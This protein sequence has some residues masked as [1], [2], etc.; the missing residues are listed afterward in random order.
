MR[1]HKNPC[2]DYNAERCLLYRGIHCEQDI[3][4]PY[5]DEVLDQCPHCGALNLKVQSKA[6]LE[7]RQGDTEVAGCKP[8]RRVLT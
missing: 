3:C 2:P 8:E 4:C 6:P 1:K 5:E 7:T